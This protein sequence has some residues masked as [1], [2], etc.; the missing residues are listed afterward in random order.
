MKKKLLFILLPMIS[1]LCS[2][3]ANKAEYRKPQE[4]I[5]ETT[6][7]EDRLFENVKLE[8]PFDPFVSDAPAIG[9]QYR[10]DGDYYVVRF[11][12]AIQVESSD[13][14][15]TTAVWNRFIYNPATFTKLVEPAD[16]ESTKAYSQLNA[17]GEN[18]YTIAQYNED[19]SSS[20]THFVTYV[21]RLLKSKYKGMPIV[22]SLTVNDTVHSKVV[23]TDPLAKTRF[24]FD[25]DKTG[26][27]LVI[28]YDS[29]FRTVD[30]DHIV[31]DYD[32]VV[33]DTLVSFGTVHLN[34][35]NQSVDKIEDFLVVYRNANGDFH[36]FGA[37][38]NGNRADGQQCEDFAVLCSGFY[39]EVKNDYDYLFVHYE[40]QEHTCDYVTVDIDMYLESQLPSNY[41]SFYLYNIDTAYN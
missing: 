16:K 17:G 19:H 21:I 24:S 1:M 29:N 27:F 3:N 40:H 4:S 38:L 34:R 10:E 31:N 18:P 2:C 41:S 11:I 35:Y 12:G 15:E 6:E 25:Y 5:I 9:M 13:L 22:V 8:N 14:S 37:N 23:V 30:A 36:I 26:Y 7:D 28:K 20:Y 33:G 32:N 39:R